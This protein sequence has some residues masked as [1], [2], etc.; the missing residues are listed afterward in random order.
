MDKSNKIRLAPKLTD[1]HIDLPP[2]TPMRVNLAAQVLSHTVAAGIFSLCQLGKLP[3]EAEATA[4][5]IETMD[6]LF[7]AFNSKAIT[8]KQKYGQ[9]MSASS[10]HIDFLNSSMKFLN[11]LKL[12]AKVVI[13][14]EKLI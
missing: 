9:A 11:E 4:D 7:N 12:S 6:Q 13:S 3:K 14:C 10:K 2:F 8:S 1:A 5:F